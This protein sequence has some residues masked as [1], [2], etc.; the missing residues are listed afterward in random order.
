MTKENGSEKPTTA[1]QQ[2]RQSR[3]LQ[4]ERFR[5]LSEPEKASQE[6]LNT[7]RQYDRMVEIINEALRS[8]QR[9]RLRPSAIQ[10]LNRISINNLEAEAGRWRNEPIVIEGSE[11]QPPPWE[12]VPKHV[13]DLCEY[14]NDNWEVRSPFHLAAYVMWRLNWIHP[15]VDGNGRTT[16]AVSYYVLCAKLGFHIPGVT[17]VAEMIAGDKGPYYEALEAADAAG[18]KGS[19][20]VSEME[21]LLSELLAR[22]MV[23]ALQR[24]DAPNTQNPVERAKSK[25][26]RT[27]TDPPTRRSTEALRSSLAIWVGAASGTL[28]LLF[29]M[30]LV[31]MSAWGRVVPHDA[32]YLIIIVLALSGSLSAGLMSGN[33]SARGA[34]PVPFANEN[35]LTVA[36]T[37]ALAVLV[38]LLMLGYQLFM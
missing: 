10:E 16:R 37:G 23:L 7:L 30:I 3:T 1:Q 38:G 12:E 33:A 26:E 24:A 21:Q 18:K 2:N 28:A 8:P 32:R 15:F 36:F 20:D 22:Q 35:P 11:H 29:F 25:I 5:P 9:F 34:I 13:D 14:V 19:I 17:T 4:R 6:A 27:R 31:L